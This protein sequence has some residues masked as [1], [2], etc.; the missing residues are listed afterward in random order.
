MKP[1]IRYTE[2]IVCFVD[3]LGF[4]S[5]IEQS[6]HDEKILTALHTMLSEL[7][8]NKLADMVFGGIPTLT[9]SGR[10]A[11]AE[12]ND[13]IATAKSTWPLCITQFSDS[14]VLSCP[15]DNLGS[16]RLL[17][18]TIYAVNQSFFKHL[19]TIMRGGIAK[20]KLIHEQNGVL[21]GPAMNAAYALESK[22]AIFP[23]ILIEENAA[24][25]LREKLGTIPDHPDPLLT[26][27]FN[28]FDGHTAV[29]I[30][31]LLCLP[32][33]SLDWGQLKSKMDS[34]EADIKQ[35]A[36]SALPKIRY[37]IDRLAQ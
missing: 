29:D 16:C 13:T 8:G 15:A 25:H 3:I 2:S 20:G 4:K 21:F 32:Q 1:H 7:Q 12:Q 27:L 10:W 14:F 26:P 11:T 18:Q 22:L 31:S 19:D 23:R 30:V 24:T 33:T 28:S 6:I 9:S 36:P 5:T 17:L 34:I 37:L 35:S